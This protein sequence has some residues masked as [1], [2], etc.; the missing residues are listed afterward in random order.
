MEVGEVAPAA[1]QS[2]GWE[3]LWDPGWMTDSEHEGPTI[4]YHLGSA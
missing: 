1:E 3:E 2:G 4:A